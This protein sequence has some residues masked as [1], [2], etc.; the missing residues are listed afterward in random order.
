MSIGIL[1]LGSIGMRHLKNA[2]S[3]GENV[4]GFDP[5]EERQA[6]AHSH[7]VDIA[8]NE[9]ALFEQVDAVVICSPNK[10]NLQNIKTAID[11]GCH[12]LVEK[13]FSHTLNGLEVVISQ[14]KK[15][16]LVLAVA[17]NLRF[18]AVSRS[19]REIIKNKKFGEVLWGR[20]ICSSYLPSWRPHQ[21]YRVNYT[22]DPQYGGVIFDVIHEI[23]LAHYLLGAA[24]AQSCVAWQ[25]GVLET[26]AE[27]CAEIVLRHGDARPV[28]SNIHLDYVSPNK[29][30]GFE[31]QMKKG[32]IRGDLF[33][34][35]LEV[36]DEQ[37]VLVR[38][39][40][41]HG[42]FNKDYVDEMKA[43]IAAFKKGEP[44]PCCADE[45]YSVLETVV[46]ARSLAG[47]PL[48]HK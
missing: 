6:L 42:S 23:D 22:T 5:D 40:A 37:D 28:Y 35:S 15:R 46:E 33:A 27:D 17:M 13:P 26:K 3:L 20:F 4:V 16:K 31:I 48:V 12:I 38:Q 11:C 1:G 18:N 7:D 8:E 45:A 43:F 47:L 36:F 9:Q 25:S 10:F 32:L 41:L 2:L 34:R 44:F 39:D 29:K 21:D 30:R 19:A 24:S 14:A